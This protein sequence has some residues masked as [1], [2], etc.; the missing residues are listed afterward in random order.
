MASRY[1]IDSSKF[2]VSVA[3]NE[4]IDH[5]SHMKSPILVVDDNA[6]M[7]SLMKL[8]LSGEGYVVETASDGATALAT[9]RQGLRPGLIFLDMIMNGVDGRTFL[10]TFETELP[11]L[12]KGTPIV[13]TSGLDASKDLK[14]SHYL[15]KPVDLTTL[16]QT[17][18]LYY[19]PKP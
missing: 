10:A 12:F 11:D 9:L 17:V 1:V 4:P 6:D 14:I 2:D 16:K 5:D 15:K 19:L 18:D 8:F 13:A 7:R 3:S